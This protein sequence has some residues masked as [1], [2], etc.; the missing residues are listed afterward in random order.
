MKLKAQETGDRLEDLSK[1]KLISLLRSTYEYKTFTDY[2]DDH[3]LVFLD[4][5][6][7][8]NRHTNKRDPRV[9]ASFSQ[10]DIMREIEKIN[11]EEGL[12]LHKYH[13]DL[14]FTKFKQYYDHYE[15]KK[16]RKIRANFE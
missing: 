7:E 4:K 11:D 13:Q 1:D 8:S 10:R 16:A 15:E 3:D 6:E 9:P 5:L 2:F 12:H 14:I